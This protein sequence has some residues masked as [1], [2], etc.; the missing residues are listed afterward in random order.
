[1]I[2]LVNK[3]I[4]YFKVILLII[5][6]TL[7]LYILL[8][9]NSYYGSNNI[10][11]FVVMCLP[12]ILLLFIFV[13]SFLY[14]KGEKNTF[15]NVASTIALIAILIIDYRTIF[16]K[17]MVLWIKGNMNFY[18]FENQMLQM[19]ILSYAMVIGNSILIIHE[20]YNNIEN[21]KGF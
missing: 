16:D 4:F 6:F 21:K 11:N 13:F 12:F 10:I 19:E 18:Y 15:F 9:M 5:I 17:N 14:K 8:S 7:T 20:K 3:L 2:D 1:M